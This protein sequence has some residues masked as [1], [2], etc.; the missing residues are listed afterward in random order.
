MIEAIRR[1]SH[2]TISI[3]TTLAAVAV[4]GVAV[5]LIGIAY[6]FINKASSGLAGEEFVFETAYDRAERGMDDE[7][8][9]PVSLRPQGHQKG[10]APVVRPRA[11]QPPAHPGDGRVAQEIGQVETA[12]PPPLEP[13]HDAQNL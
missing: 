10:R 7:E 11:G 6:M 2:V 12:G 9:R 4:I 1:Q 5:V 13:A 3:D 8:R